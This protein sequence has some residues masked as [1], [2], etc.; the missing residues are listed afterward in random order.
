MVQDF[1]RIRKG[2]D[3]LEAMEKVLVKLEEYLMEESKDF[4]VQRGVIVQFS[5]I[6]K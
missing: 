1:Y 6:R 2:S 5:R 4:K 3:V